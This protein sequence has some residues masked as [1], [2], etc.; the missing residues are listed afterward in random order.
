VKKD[1]AQDKA[2][3]V[4]K[5]E[6]EQVEQ[7][8]PKPAGHTPTIQEMLMER[9]KSLFLKKNQNLIIVKNILFKINI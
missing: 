8:K 5:P 2:E 4:K 3:P 6:Q 9:F 7:P 1:S